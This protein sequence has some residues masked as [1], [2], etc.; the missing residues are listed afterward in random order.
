MFLVLK[1]KCMNSISPAKVLELP[2]DIC[3]HCNKKCTKTGESSKAIQCEVC[4]SWIHA[5][6]E[7]LNMK[8]CDLFNKL[9]ASVGNVAYCCNLNHCFSRLNQLTANPHCVT[10]KDL[11]QVLKRVVDNHTLLQESISKVSSKIEELNSQYSDLKVKIDHL[12]ENMD[13]LEGSTTNLHQG[14]TSD[15]I[16][17]IVVTLANEEK[18]KEKR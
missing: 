3:K 1:R 7:G 16:A 4:Y 15:S 12:S 11:D 17:S 6:C 18:V 13:C 9:S 10:S 2:G 5:S 14:I 8:E